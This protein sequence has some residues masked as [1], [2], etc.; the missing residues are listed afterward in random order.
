MPVV[1]WQTPIT[2]AI[3]LLIKKSNAFITSF[4]LTEKNPQL[5]WNKC[6]GTKEDHILFLFIIDQTSDKSVVRSTFIYSS[7]DH[8]LARVGAPN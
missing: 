2:P 1:Q 4:L 7:I 8:M 5:G 3:F 6:L